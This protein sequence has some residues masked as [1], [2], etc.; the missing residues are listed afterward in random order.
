M[1]TDFVYV[2]GISSMRTEF[3]YEQLTSASNIRLVR[4]CGI[5]KDGLISAS[6]ETHNIEDKIAYTALSYCWAPA[7]VQRSII[8]NERLIS[9]GQNLWDFLEEMTST[10]TSTWY[11]IDALCINQND[12]DE[13]NTQVA[14]MGQIYHGAE[15]IVIW[16]GRNPYLE[17]SL[18]LLAGFQNLQNQN[19][20][21]SHALSDRL[22]NA[23]RDPRFTATY[24][25]QALSDLLESTY[26]Q[27]MWIIQEVALAKRAVLRCSSCQLSLDQIEK[28][29]VFCQK[30]VA[31]R[32]PFGHLTE[33]SV[34][35]SFRAEALAERVM[36][37]LNFQ[38]E[39]KRRSL[40]QLL[41]EF[42]NGQC[43]LFH[44]KIYSLLGLLDEKKHDMIKVDYRKSI[45]ALF[46]DV[47]GLCLGS[48][49]DYFRRYMQ[50]RDCLYNDSPDSGL[51]WEILQRAE[52]QPAAEKQSDRLVVDIFPKLYQAEISDNIERNYA[53]IVLQASII[54][55]TIQVATG[56]FILASGLAQNLTLGSVTN[57]N[58]NPMYWTY[59]CIAGFALSRPPGS[60]LWNSPWRCRDHKARNPQ[61]ESISLSGPYLMFK[62]ERLAHSVIKVCPYCYEQLDSRKSS[63]LLEVDLSC[64]IT[65]GNGDSIQV[66][67]KGAESRLSLVLTHS[68][69]KLQMAA[70]VEVTHT[71][72]NTYSDPYNF[73]HDWIAIEPKPGKF[74]MNQNGDM[75]V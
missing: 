38:R 73:G 57:V 12:T 67:L 52:V 37:L 23:L 26:W 18:S 20:I 16:L 25:P 59:A 49:A 10:K 55:G 72:S 17:M 60:D 64:A 29:I 56:R 31:T 28:L 19:A 9:V 71:K 3:A 15:G 62:E 51:W 2:M 43:E 36:R 58:A 41:D 66:T 48:E 22:V 40:A 14:R 6:I 7:T 27:R 54:G 45:S 69:T 63:Q 44:D 4:L 74:L 30:G 35:F 68:S 33:E 47:M 13:K 5:T 1:W 53:M 39:G 42:A 11:W 70:D 65:C 24:V 32:L 46:W 8:V 50:L 21:Q 34:P 61:H 75:T